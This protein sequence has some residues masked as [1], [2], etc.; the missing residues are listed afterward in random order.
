M[1]MSRHGE[2]APIAVLAR[3]VPDMGPVTS[4]GQFVQVLQAKGFEVERTDIPGGGVLVIVSRLELSPMFVRY[5]SCTA[6]D[7][8]DPKVPRD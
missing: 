4:P 8:K 3:K 5:E 2:C 1:L 6:F 7:R